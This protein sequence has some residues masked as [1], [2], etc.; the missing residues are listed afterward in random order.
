MFIGLGL[1][2][3]LIILGIQVW[4]MVSLKIEGEI[5][6][7]RLAV[8]L[9]VAV[10]SLLLIAN[11]FFGKTSVH[12]LVF[13]IFLSL[14]LI[15]L[16][17][18]QCWENKHEKEIEVSRIHEEINR[19]EYTIQKDPEFAGAYACLGD[20]H[21][22][23][24]EK[25]KAL[26]YYKKALSLKPEDPKIL[27]KIMFVEK[28]MELMPKL[29]RADL[30]I[31]KTEFKRFPIIFGVV[32]AVILG[33]ILFVYLLNILPAAIVFVIVVLVPIVLF[34]RWVMKL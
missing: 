6:G 28:K 7:L 5:G 17:I 30:S 1:V 27:D 16:K 23:M 15:S 24:G 29:T 20:L 33:I 8:L 19:W 11:S 10:F 26:A 31:V 9:L 25:D 32:L 4:Y 22:K 34:F 3:V 2:L 18:S 14:P 21:L 12:P 13:A